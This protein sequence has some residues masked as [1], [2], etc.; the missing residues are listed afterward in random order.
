MRGYGIATTL[1]LPFAEAVART[2]E[3]LAAQGFGILTEIDVAATM[4]A[5]LDV[6]VPPQAILGACN[7]PLAHRGLTVEPD[8]GLL[9]PCNVVVRALDGG[10]ARVSAID[11]G[12]LVETTGNADLAAVAEEARS[13]LRAA[14]EGLPAQVQDDGP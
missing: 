12:V 2:R 13:R 11:P 1:H 5:K 7:P 9:L 4:R 10:R 8:L 14:V 6:E 3:A